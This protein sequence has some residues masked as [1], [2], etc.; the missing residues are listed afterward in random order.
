MPTNKLPVQR[1]LSLIDK[2]LSHELAFSRID[3]QS[4]S[5]AHLFELSKGGKQFALLV[6]D[7]NDDGTFPLQQTRLLLESVPTNLPDVEVVPP[8]D[9]YNGSSAK[10]SFSRLAPPSQRSVLVGS[11]AALRA[12]LEWYSTDNSANQE[13]TTLPHPSNTTAAASAPSFVQATNTILY[14]PP[15]TG[16]T[17]LTATRAVEL[18]DGRA[19]SDRTKLLQRYEELRIQGRIHFVTFHQSY[20]YEE[21]VEGLRPIQ[22]T[23]GQVSFEVIP[24]AF[25]RACESASLRQHVSSALT[26]K[27]LKERTFYK[28]S[29]GESSSAEGVQVFRYCVD[30]DCVLLGWG[31]D[32]DFTG[33]ND[34]AAIR[35]KLEAD[36]PSAEKMDT[37][38]RFVN[39]FKH[40]LKVGDIIIVSNGNRSFR[41]V[42][43]V[44]GE[45]EFIEDAPFH[46]SRSVRW[47]AVF[48]AGRPASEI[49][50]KDFTMRSLHRLGGIDHGALERI[51]AEGK[52]DGAAPQPHVLIIDEINRANISKVFGELITLLEPDKRQGATNAVTLRLAYSGKDFSVPNNLHVLGTMNTA[53]RSIAVLD[54][55]LRRRFDFEELMPKPS[56][57]RA[58]AVEGVDIDLERLLAALNDRVEAVYDRDHTIGHAFFMDVRNIQDL[59]RVF[60]RKVLPLLQEYFYERWSDVRRVLNDLG[61]GDFVLRRTLPQVP[62][63][64]DEAYQ[65]EPRV[66]FSVNERPFPVV[67]Y[68]RIY[69]AG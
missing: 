23:G 2:T 26:G 30:N 50:P 34:Q 22:G 9:Y 42:A 32:V 20:G 10:R 12:L 31:D 45:Y 29:L 43:E 28:M 24:G 18:C 13:M 7:A 51:L 37:Q 55:A 48:E 66:V 19:P 69:G 4:R 44:V 64:G 6:G 65:D 33:C 54:T 68:R 38:V 21:F 27:P 5:K 36:A 57:L 39:S 61:E 15:G 17:Y 67:A 47:L 46:Q 8:G 16:K 52:K 14:G 60:R 53:D 35:S 40:E 56:E 58:V 3:D 49:N 1:A 25:R 62:P 11:E 59:E 63:D 41:G